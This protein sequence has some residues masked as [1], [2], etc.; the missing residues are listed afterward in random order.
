MRVFQEEIFGPVVS[1]TTFK[2]DDEA[3]RHRQRH[4]L[5]PRRRRLEPRRQPLLPLRP[6]HPGRPRL[7][8]L[9]PR[10][11]GP[12]GLRR[13]QAVRHRPR[14]PQD[15]ARPLPADQEHAGQLQPEEARLLLKARTARALSARAA[16]PE[17]FHDG[18]RSCQAT[19]AAGELIDEIKADHGPMLFHQSGG[20][21]DGSSPMCYPQDDFIVGDRDV[22]LGMIGDAPVY[23]SESQFEAWKHTR[24]DH[25]RRSGPG[26]HVLARQRARATVPHP[27]APHVRRGRDGLLRA[28]RECV[29]ASQ[30][31]ARLWVVV[32][33]R[34]CHFTRAIPRPSACAARA[35]APPGRGSA[36]SS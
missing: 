1:V 35:A 23:I 22:L 25:R 28:D 30:A 20:C 18:T 14:E 6:R 2:D 10:L 32:R 5:R 13:L 19:P 34:V 16:Q 12:C 26:R 24:A 21:C 31:K 7:D 36:P 33:F 8:Q 9:L 4:A 17:A 27:L 29:A 15:D 11:S 3:L